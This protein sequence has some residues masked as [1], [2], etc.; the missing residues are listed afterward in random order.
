MTST[1]QSQHRPQFL[2]AD[3]ILRTLHILS[4]LYLH[5][6][7]VFMESSGRWSNKLGEYALDPEPP[8]YP[9]TINNEVSHVRLFIA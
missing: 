3:A 6:V 1:E 8:L 4:P 2:Q 9:Q 5:S 7:D